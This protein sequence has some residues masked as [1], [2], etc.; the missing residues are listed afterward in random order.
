MA[1]TGISAISGEQIIAVGAVSAREAASATFTINGNSLQGLYD[2]VS[3]NSGSWTGG[4]VPGTTKAT[5]K[6]TNWGSTTTLGQVH[7]TAQLT[8]TGAYD[9]WMT[10]RAYTTA[11]SIWW[12][13]GYLP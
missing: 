8:T 2:T 13:S 1:I 7:C 10:N 3:N 12:A 11:N 9:Y 4:T 5:T 6:L